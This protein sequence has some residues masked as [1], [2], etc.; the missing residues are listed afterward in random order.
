MSSDSSLVYLGGQR[1]LAWEEGD[2]RWFYQSEV[3]IPT[4]VYHIKKPS[5]E[6][7]V[8]PS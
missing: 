2:E 3:M 5:A 8:A 7:K 6:K 1:T 4:L